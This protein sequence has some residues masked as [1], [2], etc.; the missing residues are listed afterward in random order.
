MEFETD[1]M[2]QYRVEVSGWDRAENFFVEKTT[3]DWN[4]EGK[5]DIA[6]RAEVREGS[7]LFVRLLQTAV[8]VNNIP[9]AYQA[10]KIATKD[11]S[12][13]TRLWLEWLRP[14]SESPR[15]QEQSTLKDTGTVRVA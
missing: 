10:V 2:D 11:P 6:L 7:V 14:R 8:D 13:L 4:Q 15:L 3:L 5:K 9:I 1:S 12:G